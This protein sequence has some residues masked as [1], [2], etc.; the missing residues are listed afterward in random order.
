MTIV[1]N[2]TSFVDSGTFLRT[3]EI[4]HKDRGEGKVDS[5]DGLSPAARPQ[6]VPGAVFIEAKSGIIDPG[7]NQRR[8]FCPDFQFVWT[9]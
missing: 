3:V 9:K 1:V 7:L 6:E 2:K 5:E 8:Q 4:I